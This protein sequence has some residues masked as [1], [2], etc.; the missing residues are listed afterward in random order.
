M[1]NGL[2]IWHYPHRSVL[3]NVAF[4]AE[5]GFESVSIL[6]YHMDQVCSDEQQSEA[7][8]RLIADKGLVLTVHHK[9]PLSHSEESV[10]SFHATI[11]RFAA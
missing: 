3:E 1:K 10:A 2:A 9:L 4:F 6:G 11:D 8:A 7:L 5:Q